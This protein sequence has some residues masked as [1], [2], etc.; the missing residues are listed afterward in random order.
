MRRMNEEHSMEYVR[1]RVANR[2]NTNCYIC[3]RSCWRNNKII[4]CW[5]YET[6]SWIPKVNGFSN[7][8][9]DAVLKIHCLSS[10]DTGFV[11][12]ASKDIKRGVQAWTMISLVLLIELS[13]ANKIGG[14]LSKGIQ[15][16]HMQGCYHGWRE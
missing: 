10:V 8:N 4:Q 12:H 1:V 9:N 16:T 7:A 6:L 11:A 2:R 15:R 3:L 14:M 13:Y 5:Y